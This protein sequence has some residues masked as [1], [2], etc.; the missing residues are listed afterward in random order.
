MIHEQADISD[1]IAESAKISALYSSLKRKGLIAETEDKLTTMGTEL[2]VFMDSKD[3]GKIVKHKVNNSIFEDWWKAF[4]STDTFNHKGRMFTGCRSLRQNKDECRLK[5][6]KILIEGEHSAQIL[7][8]ALKYDVL[9]KKE[10]SVKTGTNK[11]TYMQN[12]LTYLNQRSY[13]GFIE[14]I[15][16]GTVIEESQTFTG[17][18]DI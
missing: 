12:S 11:L 1:L 4:P 3:P 9:S 17:G 5:F 18:R 10:A 14:L 2:I 16:I 15:Q 6:D 13:E 7:I 8:D